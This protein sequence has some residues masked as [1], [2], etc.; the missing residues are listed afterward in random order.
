[1]VK[2][3]KTLKS[4]LTNK[5]WDELSPSPPRRVVLASSSTTY[6]QADGTERYALTDEIV[7]KVDILFKG[8]DQDVPMEAPEDVSIGD[9][10]EEV[11]ALRA[12]VKELE[13]ELKAATSNKKKRKKIL[14]RPEHFPARGENAPEQID[15]DY[16]ALEDY[17]EDWQHEVNQYLEE[18]AMIEAA[19][20]GLRKQEQTA[21]SSSSRMPPIERAV[22]YTLRTCHQKFSNVY[23]N[24][25]PYE[26]IAACVFKGDGS[27]PTREGV[28]QL[29]YSMQD[30]VGVEGEFLRPTLGVGRPALIS[31][32]R[33]L[34]IAHYLM[35]FK[36][37]YGR[38]NL[39][40]AVAAQADLFLYKVGDAE[41]RMS[42][43]TIR[44]IMKS[45]CFD[46]GPEF[47]WWQYL[48]PKI[49]KEQK[50]KKWR[51]SRLTYAKKMVQVPYFRP[52]EVRFHNHWS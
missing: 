37:K 21:E 42:D 26:T 50:G 1:M 32:D 31:L 23:L 51:E 15:E 27:H 38:V 43:S 34:E 22:A 3:G 4:Y 44:N 2:K 9:D 14:D 12:R 17:D 5:S 52:A 36:D 39:E 49:V 41:K 13:A 35:E 11:D 7:P 30:Q 19:M 40:A 48:R 10:K 20:D 16:G 45:Y 24:P 33:K 8:D 46:D 25:L 47:G 18:Q 29:I 6:R 28:R